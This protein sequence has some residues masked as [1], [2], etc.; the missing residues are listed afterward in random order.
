VGPRVP[1]PAADDFE[2]GQDGP[3]SWQEDYG[4]YP[5]VFPTLKKGGL[6]RDVADRMKADAISIVEASY[7][8]E[9]DAQTWL[10]RLLEQVAPKLDRGFGVTIS[11]YIPEMRAE[12][13]KMLERGLKPALV[14]AAMAMIA[15]YPHI[16]HQALT[17]GSPHE[18]A[19]QVMGLTS[20]EARAWAPFVEHMHPLGVR[21]VVGV[22]AR[23]PCGHAIFFSAPSPDLDRPT[24]Q[25]RVVWSRIAAHISAGARLRR[26]LPA[27][28]RG[29]VTDGAEAVLSPSGAIAHAEAAAQSRDARDSL[30]RAARS[31]DRARSKAR[32]DDAE[33]LELWQGLIAG[34][35]S[36]VDRFDTDGR[37]F[38][39]ARK[40]DPDVRDPRALTARERHVLAYAAMGHPLKLIAYSL[41][42][43]LSTV[44]VNRRNAMRKLGLQHHADIVALFGPALGAA[45][46]GR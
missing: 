38:L 25:D 21:D 19:S 45:A 13:V 39:V 1:E 2:A 46:Q 5:G 28:A 20:R 24:R 18:T 40:N 32:P 26:A 22:L 4:K 41:G 29:D 3:L 12:D 15:A 43:S 8:C 27:L 9:S 36:L 11:Q 6:D 14:E 23:D 44:S 35:W 34:R 30:R 17:V 42:L 37:R 16:F 31:I 10:H 7:N 33:A